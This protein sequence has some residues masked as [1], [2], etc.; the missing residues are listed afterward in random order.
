MYPRDANGPAFVGEFALIMAFP[1]FSRPLIVIRVSEP[2][3]T[4]RIAQCCSARGAAS[5]SRKVYSIEETRARPSGISRN[6]LYAMLRAGSLSSVVIR[7]RRFVSAEAIAALIS[8]S[9][10]I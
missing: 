8:N 2:E 6:S 3:V 7:C 10:S 9:G 4:L 1:D 5:K